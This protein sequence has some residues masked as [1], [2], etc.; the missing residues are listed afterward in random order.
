MITC[1]TAEQEQRFEKLERR[2]RTLDGRDPGG[3]DLDP[4]SV[5]S[6]AGKR[7]SGVWRC[8]AP[9]S[10]NNHEGRVEIHREIA[11]SCDKMLRGLAW[12]FC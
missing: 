12:W 8:A 6:G 4:L 10:R 11:V 1:M 3:P 7:G 5:P 9:P 2:V